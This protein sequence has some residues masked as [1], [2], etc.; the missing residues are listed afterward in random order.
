MEKVWVI[1]DPDERPRVRETKPVRKEKNL[2]AGKSPA[3]AYSLSM[4]FWGAGQLYNHRR[5]KGAAFMVLMFLA[6]SGTLLALFYRNG[7]LSFLAVL[8]ISRTNSFLLAEAMLLG[9]LI[10]WTYNAGDA[11]HQARKEQKTPFTGVSSRLY[12]ALCSLLV[13]GWG[14][15]L[16]GQPIKG[17]VFTGFSV[18]GLFSIITLPLAYLAWPS[19][20]PSDT[21][22]MVEVIFAGTILFTPVIPFL[23]IISAYDAFRISFDDY[24]KEPL[25]ERM[26]AA[27]NRR[28]VQGWV[29]GVF[30]QI[31]G[32]IALGLYLALCV[33]TVRDYFP[34]SYYQEVLASASLLMKKR[35]MTLLPELI[36]RLQALV[37]MVGR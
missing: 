23:W 33:M 28:R 18:I 31:K 22:A 8:G 11:Y 4:F 10:F 12:P 6:G 32:T 3:V 29:R 34:A 2:H 13:P 15:F 26:K 25:W 24:R 20:E 14:Q 21:R 1:E 36:D 30:P 9:I 17:S 16:N 7:L 37:M 19:L 35:G 27:N 5:G